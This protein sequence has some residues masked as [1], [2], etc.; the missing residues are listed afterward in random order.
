[1]EEEIVE[2][3]DTQPEGP[4]VETET[5]EEA[6]DVLKGGP[7]QEPTEPQFTPKHKSWEE[8]EKARTTLEKD[9]H[10]AKTETAQL[11]KQLETYEQTL[12]SMKGGRELDKQ[13]ADTPRTRVKNEAM[14]KIE[15]LDQQLANGEINQEEHSDK[16]WDIL[17]EMNERLSDAMVEQRLSE[18]DSRSQKIS[19]AE[20]KVKDAGLSLMVKNEDGSE[21]DAGLSAFWAVAN[22]GLVPPDLTI[23]QEV[24]F[25]IDQLKI[26]NDALIERFKTDQKGGGFPKPLGKGGKVPR[27]PEGEEGSL[28]MGDGFKKAREERRIKNI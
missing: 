28:T 11:R 12:K 14:A 6:P 5:P 21:N 20:K 10:T 8:T 18:R 2:G 24:D 26:Y 13:Q 15:R 16:V 19:N 9:F 1:M 27:I 23:E 4:D 25:C 22:S 17:A 3:Q 7:G